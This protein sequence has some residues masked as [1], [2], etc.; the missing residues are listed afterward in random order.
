M[1]MQTKR[2]YY[3]VL[4]VSRNASAD[5]IKKAYRKLALKYHPDRNPENKEAEE[6]FKESAEAY[7]VLSDPEK[8]AQ[9][10][11][12]G[13]SLGGA[14]F[15]GFQGFEETFRG[16]GDIFGDLFDDFF[17]TSTRTRGG[18]RRGTNLEAPV[19]ITLEEA[20]SG[21]EVS[22]SIPRLETC[23]ACSGTGAAPGTKKVACTECRGVGEIRI[24][25][26]FFSLRRTCPRCHGEGERIDKPCPGCRGTGRVEKT[27]K[28]NV[29]IPPGIDTDSRLKI[30][31]EGE[32]GERGGR[33]GDL[34]VRVI[35]KPHSI[36]E[37]HGNDLYCE[38]L[39]PFSVAAL[40]GDTAVPTIDGKVK[41]HIPP[42]TPSGKVFRLREKG[43]P[44]L[45]ATGRGDELVRIEIEV[46]SRLDE[47]ERAILEEWAKL[48]GDSVGTPRKK[49]LFD[50]FRESF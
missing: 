26:G 29:K 5:E 45:N 25:Q 39:I 3:E 49:G 21:K 22:L 11:Q 15:Q 50:R 6:K 35:V 18:S 16:F 40:G 28:L 30:S 12:F 48:R 8:R 14:G 31:G 47:K 37:R 9:Y 42:G 32:A 4:G 17:G 38:M 43:V 36:L 7:A 10:D 20:C 33:P 44:F 34:F 13:H 2:D 19:E 46:P 23:S 24:T 1:A 41:L 27:R